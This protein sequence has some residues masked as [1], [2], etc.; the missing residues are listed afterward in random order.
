MDQINEFIFYDYV[1]DNDEI[2]NLKNLCLTSEWNRTN[3][4]AKRYYSA[5]DD[6][7]G[8]KLSFHVEQ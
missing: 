5:V 3:G 8:G 1:Y 7:D 4:K 6:F 2:L